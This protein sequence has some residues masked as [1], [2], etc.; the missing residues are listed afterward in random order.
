MK[1]KRITSLL[2]AAFFLF[3]TGAT[4]QHSEHHP[5]QTT[6]KA[7]S[8]AS[9][10]MVAHHQEMERLVNQLLQNFAALENE[11]DPEIM[12]SKLAEHRVLL[13]QLQSKITRCSEMMEKT[14]KQ[15]KHSCMGGS[16][17]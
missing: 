8:Q 5:S 11:K 10:A 13:K 2:L 12:R 4:A 9:S 16:G 7:D 17:H 14:G 15:G 1:H 6:S 3:A